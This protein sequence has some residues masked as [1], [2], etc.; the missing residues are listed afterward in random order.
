MTSGKKNAETMLYITEQT[1]LGLISLWYKLWET[2]SRKCG[3]SPADHL[4]LTRCVK[5]YEDNGGWKSTCRN[6]RVVAQLYFIFLPVQTEQFTDI[7]FYSQKY[8]PTK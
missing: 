2:N 4:K 6:G 5:Q 1:N 8:K 7:C 3:Y